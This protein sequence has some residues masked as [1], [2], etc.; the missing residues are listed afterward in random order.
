MSFFSCDEAPCVEQ[1][2][3]IRLRIEAREK[4][5]GEVSVRRVLPASRQRTV[6]PFVFFD[7]MGPV[8]FPP[9]K[10]IDVRPHPHIGIAT[11]WG[12]YSP[13]TPAPLISGAQ[14]KNDWQAGNFPPV[15]DDDER[16]P[17]PGE[18]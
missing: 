11:V 12:W 10:G 4:S 9:G 7:H 8:E 6:G 16:I 3:R 18:G 13:F 1:N 2:S 5:I 15:P 14:A 17:H